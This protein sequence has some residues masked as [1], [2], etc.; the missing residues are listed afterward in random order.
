MIPDCTCGH[1]AG[2][3]GAVGPHP[4]ED[5]RCNVYRAK[6]PTD[7]PAP[8]GGERRTVLYGCSLFVAAPAEGDA[9]RERAEVA[10]GLEEMCFRAPLTTTEQ[11]VARRAAQLLRSPAESDEWWPTCPVC[12]GTGELKEAVQAWDVAGAPVPV[13]P[14][15][16]DGKVDLGS[17]LTARSAPAGPQEP[18]VG[19]RWRRRSVDGLWGN[20]CVADYKPEHWDGFVVEVQDLGVIR[21]P[22][23]P[24]G[25]SD[26]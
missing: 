23:P 26:G 22:V 3:H 7:A 5:C 18:V 15:C 21:A 14:H 4:C 13:C 11:K 12:R 16:D 25:A 10:N 24:A 17:L 1:S 2:R 19:Y 20:W 8:A 6:R 9:E